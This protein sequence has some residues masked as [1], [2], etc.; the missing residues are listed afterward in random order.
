MDDVM[1]MGNIVFS[2]N[3]YDKIVHNVMRIYDYR[4]LF[5][6]LYV[7]EGTGIGRFWKNDADI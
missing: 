7:N 6:N 5:F 3:N 2:L 4:L 1:N